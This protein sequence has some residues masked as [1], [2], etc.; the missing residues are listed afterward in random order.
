MIGL[1][2]ASE[3]LTASLMFLMYNFVVL[4]PESE[5][6]LVSELGQIAPL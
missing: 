1:S 3:L 6:F 4:S 5:P 2:T